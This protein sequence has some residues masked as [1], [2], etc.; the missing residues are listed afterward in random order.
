VQVLDLVNKIN[1]GVVATHDDEIILQFIERNIKTLDKIKDKSF[2][3]I[4]DS[5]EKQREESMQK[6]YEKHQGYPGFVGGKKCGWCGKEFKC[7]GALMDH[8]RKYSADWNPVLKKFVPFFQDQCHAGHEQIVRSHKKRAF[9]DFLAERFTKGIKTCPCETC[10]QKE[11]EF[12][13]VNHMIAHFSHISK[14]SVICPSDLADFPSHLNLHYPEVERLLKE[15]QDAALEED[16]KRQ[17]GSCVICLDHAVDCM[18]S[19][20]GHACACMECLKKWLFDIPGAESTCPICREVVY[21]IVPMKYIPD[22]SADPDE[23]FEVFFSGR[24]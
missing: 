22:P 9:I 17:T 20:C 2:V 15:E 11:R 21:Q 8:V 6:L 23:V 1:A 16:F 3:Q 18:C 4:T 14:K 12:D 19:P 10:D 13:S 5:G 7:R 24:F